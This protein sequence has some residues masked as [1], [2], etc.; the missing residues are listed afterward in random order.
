[1]LPAN[2]LYAKVQVLGP[3]AFGD[4][5]GAQEFVMV[6]EHLEEPE[7]MEET[8]VEAVE[9]QGETHQEEGVHGPVQPEGEEE[10][11]DKKVPLRRRSRPEPG[12][13]TEQSLRTGGRPR[14]SPSATAGH[15]GQTEEAGQAQVKRRRR[16]RSLGK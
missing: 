7:A 8:A 6:D 14:I 12:A 2:V 9:G 15:V 13:L 4:M 11:W 1:M 10:P 3:G 5:P 16:R